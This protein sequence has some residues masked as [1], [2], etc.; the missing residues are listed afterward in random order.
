MS[1][2]GVSSILN[3]VNLISTIN[4]CDYVVSVEETGPSSTGAL[5]IMLHS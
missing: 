3:V 4:Q 2:A 5:L 1:V